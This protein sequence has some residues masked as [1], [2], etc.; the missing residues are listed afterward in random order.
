M[1]GLK[2]IFEPVR[3]FI[4]VDNARHQSFHELQTE[5]RP[6]CIKAHNVA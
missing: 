6:T 1:S 5:V 3:L 4:I 2:R